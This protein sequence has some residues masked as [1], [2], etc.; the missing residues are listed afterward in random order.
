MREGSNV[1]V[2]SV[3]T[4]CYN[5]GKSL[6][7]TM[8][9][10][11]AQTYAG[12]EYIIQD[13]GSAD[14]TAELLEN[15]RLRFLE[16]GIT[17]R[18][19]MEKDGGIYDAMNKALQHAAGTWINFMNAGDC[20]YSESVLSDIFEERDY[21]NS[22]VLYGD[23]VECEYG[24]YYLFRKAFDSI[25]SRM[26]FS[27]QSA[28]VRKELLARLPFCTDYRIGADYDFLLTV[29]QKGFFFTDTNNIVCIVSKDGVSSMKLYDTFMETVHIWEGHGIHRYDERQMKKKA[30]ELKI[31]QFVVD[32]FPKRIKKAIRRLQIIVRRQNA[33]FH[34]PV[35]EMENPG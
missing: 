9:S 27:H 26:P 5:P 23:A 1:P 2:V 30:A 4:V 34:I 3:I 24:R 20:F 13:G 22:A 31:K 6:I 19:S 11:L 7:K 29:Y 32:Y 14:G 18:C 16:K 15:Y 33:S 21:A 12:F 28:F 25:E 10:I 17:L 8:E 35:W